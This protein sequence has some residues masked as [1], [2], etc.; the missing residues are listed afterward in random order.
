MEHPRGMLVVRARPA[1]TEDGPSRSDDLRLHEQIGERGVQ[2]IGGSGCERDLGV[3]RDV[4]R[5]R[6]P[7]A[8]GDAQPAQLDVVLRRDDDFRMC[9]EVVVGAAKL[10]ARFAEDRFVVRGTLQRWLVR[11]RPELTARDVADVAER[12]PVVTG[13]VLAPARDGQVLPAAAA[14]TG[15]RDHDVITAVGQQLHLRHRRVGAA[16]HAHR[17]FGAGGSPADRGKLRRM[18]EQRRAL[19]HAFLQQQER[20]LEPRVRFEALL[21]RPGE[22]QMRQR[23]QDHALVMRHERTHDGARLAARHAGRRVVDRLVESEAPVETLADQP[24]QVRAG[25]LRRHH[26]RQRRRIG[27]DHQVFGQA[28]LEPQAGHAERAVLIVEAR[29]DCVVAGLRDAP[30]HAAL[31]AVGDLSRHHHA[32]GL[33]EQRVVVGR[34]HQQRHQVLEHRAAPRQQHGLAARG[35]QQTPEREPVL[36]RQLSLRDG[37]ETREPRLG[38]QQIV[39]AVIAPVLADVVPDREQVACTIV[40]KVVLHLRHRFALTGQLF[41]RRH[42]FRARGPCQRDRC[43]QGS[44]HERSA[45]GNSVRNRS[46]IVGS[47]FSSNA[48][49]L[50]QCRHFAHAGEFG[51]SARRRRQRGPGARNAISSR[52]QAPLPNQ[53]LC[54]E[55]RFTGDGWVVRGRRLLHARDIAGDAATLGSS[56]SNHCTVAPMVS[57]RESKWSPA[58]AAGARRMRG[59]QSPRCR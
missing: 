52:R 12:A 25:R 53:R 57:G 14:A 48:G 41:D 38:G 33:V 49:Q 1:R 8:I 23:Q 7:R 51:Q 37:H 34:H 13:G 17:R 6:D 26:Q 54:P 5:A 19:R 56:R 47:S 32:A 9:L 24:L 58:R 40:E 59:R 39:V 42:A 44:S 3:A 28:A 36:L 11:R 10:R 22:Q 4:D 18:R 50:A 16:Q 21:H 2:R 27:C 15:V 30:W 43:V 31:L 46:S 45:A 35:R 20:G 29:I 55:H